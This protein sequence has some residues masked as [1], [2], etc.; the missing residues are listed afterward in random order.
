[1]TSPDPA[2]LPPPPDPDAVLNAALLRVL[3]D[4]LD[5]YDKLTGTTRTDV[6]DDLD[7]RRIAS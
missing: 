4:W 7:L 2:N 1:M 3:A 6:Q 5:V